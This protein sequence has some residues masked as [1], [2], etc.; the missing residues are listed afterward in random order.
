MLSLSKHDNTRKMSRD[1]EA[2]FQQ[3]SDASSGP[4]G[5]AFVF[6]VVRM[7]RVERMVRKCSA[8]Q[9]RLSHHFHPCH[10]SHR[11]RIRNAPTSVN[12]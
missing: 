4:S 2:V 8:L 9:V 1:Q 6:L 5:G 11:I 12:R 10:H 7:V 3:N